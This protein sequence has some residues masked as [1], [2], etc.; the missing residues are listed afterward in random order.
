MKKQSKK[1]AAIAAV[2]GLV[3]GGLAGAV[4]FPVQNDVVVEK[5]VIEKVDV[6]FP[7]TEVVEKIVEVEVPVETFV[8]VDNGDMAFVLQRLEDMEVIAD[9]EEIVMEL[10]AEDAALKGAFDFVEENKDELF[11]MLEKAGLVTDEDDVEIIK[12]YDDFEDVEILKSDFDDEEY[13][14]NLLYK[15]EDLEEEE[16][17]KSLVKVQLE[18]GEFEILKVV[19]Q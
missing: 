17:F 19:K 18:D 12:V 13:K 14:F 6:P 7:V 10:K 11:D 9:A 1:L 5:T 2:S 3:L 16:K 8:E 15:V 4:M